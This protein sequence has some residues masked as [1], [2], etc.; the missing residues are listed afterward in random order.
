MTTLDKVQ[1][2]SGKVYKGHFTLPPKT[3][4]LVLASLLSFQHQVSVLPWDMS[5]EFFLLFLKFILFYVWFLG[6]PSNAQVLVLALHS[7]ITFGGALGTIWG[8]GSRGSNLGLQKHVL[9]SEPW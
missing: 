7:G 2:E 4:S 3:Q 1:Q 9:P 6:T 8:A 5:Y